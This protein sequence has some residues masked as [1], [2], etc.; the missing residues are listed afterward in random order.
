[1]AKQKM[2]PFETR[3]LEKLEEIVDRF[4]TLIELSVPPLKTEGLGKTEAK[5]LE[6]CDM[7]HTA[8]DMMKKLK[9]TKNLIDVTL[10]KLRSKGF[11]RSIKF[12]KKTYHV[13]TR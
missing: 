1:M 5:V 6:L 10:H 8:K 12:G 9:K 3:M 7:K 4:D 2:T 11:I 13:R